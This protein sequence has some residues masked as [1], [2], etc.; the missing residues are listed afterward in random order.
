MVAIGLASQTIMSRGDL[1]HNSSSPTT[2]RRGRAS[3]S[4]SNNGFSQAIAAISEGRFSR[5]IRF[6]TKMLL[7][8][9]EA[10]MR[11]STN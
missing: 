10:S 1:P 4:P 5:T 3:L 11:T 8:R 9:E 7:I 6:S 2:Q